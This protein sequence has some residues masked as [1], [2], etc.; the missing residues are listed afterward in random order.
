MWVFLGNE[1]ALINEVVLRYFTGP[2]ELPI[3]GT[4][5]L[6]VTGDTTISA[7]TVDAASGGAATGTLSSETLSSHSVD[8]TP[9]SSGTNSALGPGD[10][11]HAINTHDHDISVDDHATH[12]HTFTGGG[13]G[14]HTHPIANHTAHHHALVW[15]HTTEDLA[16]T[17]AVNQIEFNINGE[18]GG[19]T[20][21]SGTL[22]IGTSWSAWY[23]LDITAQVRDAVT[24]RPNATVIQIEARA[25]PAFDDP[26]F[27]C[28]LTAQVQVRTA[29]QQMATFG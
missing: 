8:A 23:E 29:I 4:L 9:F 1:A 20:Y 28:Q 18:G 13:S 16:L 2:V 15:G 21:R 6:P 5:N 7:H 17:Y 11:F 14:S 3:S 27:S 12:T 10:H 26:T 22:L 19:A 24:K 25:K